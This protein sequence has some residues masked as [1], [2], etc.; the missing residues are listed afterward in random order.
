MY[1]LFKLAIIVLIAPLIVVLLFSVCVP[2][3]S[4]TVI[5]ALPGHIH[6]LHVIFK[7]SWHKL[8]S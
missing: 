7:F 4:Q 1:V 2:V 8:K 5:V 6:F 3:C